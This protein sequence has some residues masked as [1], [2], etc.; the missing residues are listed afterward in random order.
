VNGVTISY[1]TPLNQNFRYLI[2]RDQTIMEM[3]AVYNTTGGFF[4]SASQIC[5]MYLI[6]WGASLVPTMSNAANASNSS[7]GALGQNMVGMENWWMSPLA[8]G[9]GNGDL[10]GDNEREKPY[11]DLYPR[12]TTK[13]NTY[14][15]HMRVQT[16]RQLPRSTA[17]GGPLAYA[18]WN[19]GKDAVLAEYRGSATIERYID[20]ADPRIGMQSYN[21]QS[22]TNPDTQSMERLYRFRTVIAKKFSPTD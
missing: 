9:N 2:D 8:T 12:V 1:P 15:V 14:T 16:L 21:G 3:D 22:Q 13:S 20:P 6:P 18:S 4:K 17:T 10:T 7:Q 11:A 5:E 19:E